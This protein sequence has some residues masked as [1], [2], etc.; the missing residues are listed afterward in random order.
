[1]TNPSFFSEEDKKLQAMRLAIFELTGK[2]NLSFTAPPMDPTGKGPSLLPEKDIKSTPY[3]L[4]A[5]D[6]AKEL[7]NIVQSLKTPEQQRQTQAQSGVQGPAPVEQ[8]TP[9]PKRYDERGMPVVFLPRDKKL[10]PKKEPEV[11]YAGGFS[12][13]AKAVPQTGSN[14]T[15]GLTGALSGASTGAALSGGNPFAVGAGA[16]LG[17]FSGVMGARAQRK[18]KEKIEKENKAEKERLEK[19]RKE[20][21]EEARRQKVYDRK[22]SADT[23]SF[24]NLQKAIANALNRKNTTQISYGSSRSRAR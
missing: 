9:A 12:S 22:Q 21:K 16:I 6:P 19:I 15:G 14:L 17:A 10:P 23:A 13:A 2:D 20:E 5:K 4:G 24:S 11:D 18:E 3:S 8:Q 1:M 7:Q